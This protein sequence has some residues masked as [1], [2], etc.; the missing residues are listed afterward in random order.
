MKLHVTLVAVFAATTDGDAEN[1]A[2]TG[3]TGGGS[4][5]TNTLRVRVPATFVHVSVYVVPVLIVMLV[6]CPFV[7]APT[8]GLIEHDGAGDGGDRYV[9]AHVTFVAT[10]CVTDAGVAVKLARF[11]GFGGTATTTCRDA[12][13]A[14]F[15]HVSVNVVTALIVIAIG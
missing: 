2:S 4:A 14:V 6:C 1:V 11:G 15:E 3:A 5:G 7:T 10:P 9:H 8:V 12:M 13:P